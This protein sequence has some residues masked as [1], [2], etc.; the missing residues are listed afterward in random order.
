[1][2]SLSGLTADVL[3]T[4]VMQF[5]VDTLTNCNLDTCSALRWHGEPTKLRCCDCGQDSAS[6]TVTGWVDSAFSSD[7]GLNE[8]S[9]LDCPSLDAT[10]IGLAVARC[11]PSPQRELLSGDPRDAVAAELGVVLDC[12][13]DAFG[14]CEAN[15]LALNAGCSKVSLGRFVS[16]RSTAETPYGDEGAVGWECAGWVFTVTVA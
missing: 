14:A 8:V 11:W 10:Q 2:A 3:L 9:S 4:N 5:V 6:Y 12:L 15:P 13:R 1:M 7:G 16:R